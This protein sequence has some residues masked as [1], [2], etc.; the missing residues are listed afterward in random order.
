MNRLL[1]AA[2]LLA[3]PEAFAG[4]P[5]LQLSSDSANYAVGATAHLMARPLVHPHESS[6]DFFIS[7]TLNA[8]PLPL[9]Q[10]V[11]G[12]GI[13]SVYLSQGGTYVLSAQLFL[14]NARLAASLNDSIRSLN[15]ANEQLTTQL[16]QT[17]DPALQANL[18]A[19]ISGNA[20][21]IAEATQELQQIRKPFGA[22]QSIS[23]TAQ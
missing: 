2:L 17:S 20:Q 9:N 16:N 3:S 13:A 1:L 14:E 12:P 19:E 15:L 10:V 7:A 23:F 8:A 5:L 21:Q 18:Q 4:T 6:D 11:N 22:S